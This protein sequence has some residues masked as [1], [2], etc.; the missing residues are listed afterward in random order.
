MEILLGKVTQQ[1][2]NYAIRSGITITA[3]YAFRQSSRLLKAVEG[4][5]KRQLQALQERLKSKI[6]IISPAIDMIELI[7]ARGNTSLE[8]AV[9]LTRG[10]RW[11][12]QNLGQRIA[13][14]AN[15]EELLRRGSSKA[16][17]KDHNEFMIKKVIADLKSLL[18]RIEDA[19]PLINLAITTSGANLSST[20][21]PTVSPSRLLQASTF[22]TAGDNQYSALGYKSVQIGPTFTL[23][24]YMLF[25]GHVR[26]LTEEDIRAST[27]KEVMHKARVKLMRVPLNDVSN[28]PDPSSNA[29]FASSVSSQDSRQDFTKSHMSGGTRAD[30]FAYQIVAVE[31]LD[32]DRVH[33]YEDEDLQPGAY[34]D[35]NLAGMREAIPVHQVSRIFYADTGKILNIGSDTEPNSPILLI[36]RDVNGV[37]PRKMMERAES[38]HPDESAGEEESGE[39]SLPPAHFDNPQSAIDAQLHRESRASSVVPP[40]PPKPPFSHELWHIPHDLDPEWLAFEVYKEAPDS[41]S[42]AEEDPTPAPSTPSHKRSTSRSPSLDPHLTTALSD[43]NVNTP[44]SSSRP[45]HHMTQPHPPPPPSPSPFTPQIITSLSLL[46]TLLRLLSLQQFQQTSHLA[47]P[48]EFLNFFLSETAT[49]GAATGDEAGRRRIRAEARQRVGFD[50]YDESPVK[51]RG[52][53]Y[54]YRGGTSQRGEGEGD[55]RWDG[56]GEGDGQGWEDERGNYGEE[57]DAGSVDEGYATHLSLREP[58]LRLR[59]ESPGFKGRSSP[60]S[61]LRSRD[62]LSDGSSPRTPSPLS[63]TA[64]GRVRGQ[65]KEEEWVRRGSPLAGPATPMTDEGVVVSPD[66]GEKDG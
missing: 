36:K 23:S 66:D 65:R 57:W 24:L 41:S 61:P 5:E 45:K 19:V 37:A 46:E 59:Q 52:E 30:E 32:D 3:G 44:P 20:L 51:R 6:D 62:A 9:S 64:V 2:M 17:S 10:L 58:P 43:L 31:D 16:K 15:E 1:A 29:N 27:W 22:L 48:D 42:E 33:T 63:R 56:G 12:I 26:A 35:V 47:I 39:E 34:G 49:T 55:G 4:D 25:A 14:A 11:D 54:Q 28:L 13:S 21:P 38:I 60:K 8:S 53:E 50:P 7:S 18:A 40:S